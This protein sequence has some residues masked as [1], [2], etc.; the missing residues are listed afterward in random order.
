MAGIALYKTGS[1]KF[2]PNVRKYISVDGGMGDNIRPALYDSK[3]HAVVA[4][5]M[6]DTR[7]DI[8]TIL[9]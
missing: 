2:I 5:R 3:Y 4:N 1:I 7:K 9:F 6:S 8:I